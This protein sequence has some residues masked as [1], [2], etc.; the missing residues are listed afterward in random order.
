MEH[1]AQSFSYS[2]SAKEQEEI[3]NIRE[4]YIPREEDTL[5]HLRKL[6]AMVQN[7][8][9]VCALSVGSIG[10]LMMGLGMSMC[11]VWAGKWFAPGIFVGIAGIGLILLAY[12][13]YQRTLAK[14]REKIAPEMIRLT[15]ELLK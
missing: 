12:P 1:K 10:T 4:K 2:Y 3:R 9:T 15:D 8:A 14:Q 13:I 5:Q 7:Q 11:M 6:D